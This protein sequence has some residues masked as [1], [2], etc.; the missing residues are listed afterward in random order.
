MN[1]LQK[2]QL[3]FHNYF[4][5]R[6]LAK[7]SVT[8]NSVNFEKAKT[9]GIV[10]TTAD[11]AEVKA[12]QA[13]CKTL[14]KAGKKVEIL[15]YAGK[16]DK[17][18]TIDL[19]HFTRKDLNWHLTPKTE[20]ISSFIKKDFDILVNFHAGTCRPL[21]YIAA[22]SH[23][24]CRVGRYHPDQTQCYDLMVT[25]KEN[26]SHKA[27]SDMVFQYLKMINKDNNVKAAV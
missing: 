6:E 9:F 22:C 5:K 13:F 27:Y 24:H 11:L 7:L 2:I 21:E 23:A 19:P 17:N 8:R 12:M 4:L 20:A 16:V 25:L 18:T 14:E 26:E 3:Y 1:Q 15:G 10:F